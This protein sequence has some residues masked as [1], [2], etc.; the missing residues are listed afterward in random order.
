KRIRTVVEDLEGLSKAIAAFPKKGKRPEQFLIDG[1][2]GAS[3]GTPNRPGRAGELCH[4]IALALGSNTLPD[5]KLPAR[6]ASIDV[7]SVA[8]NDLPA[9]CQ[10]LVKDGQADRLRVVS[11]GDEIH[12]GGTAKSP[13]D[14]PAFRE[15]LKQKKVQPGALEL[16]SLDDAK[17]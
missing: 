16:K 10:K 15:F 12:I 11:L 14:D 1:V 6:N 17:L 7:R 2:M 3:D 13:D 8:T 5:V 9:Y 4:E